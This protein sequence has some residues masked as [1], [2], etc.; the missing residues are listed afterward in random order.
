MDVTAARWWTCTLGTL[1]V[2]GSTVASALGPHPFTSDVWLGP[3]VH[4]VPEWFALT[5][6]AFV[7]SVTVRL[8]IEPLLFSASAQ[9][10]G[11]KRQL[12]TVAFAVFL[13]VIL[14]AWTWGAVFAFSTS[15]SM[16]AITSV[17]ADRSNSVWTR[18][19]E[20]AAMV[21]TW[22]VWFFSL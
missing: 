21:V 14:L 18:L 7:F 13:S 5:L 16:I 20:V 17:S 12:A 9:K 11:S 8:T 6:L 22:V 19:K 2:V 4:P 10:R 3:D 1:S 15:L